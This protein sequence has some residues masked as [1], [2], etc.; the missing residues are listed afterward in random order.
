MLK[1]LRC[2]LTLRVLCSSSSEQSKEPG[3]PVFFPNALLAESVS[4]CLQTAPTEGASNSTELPQG[5]KDE[6][7]R[8]SDNQ[9]IYQDLLVSRPFYFCEV[10]I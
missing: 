8:P 7:Y 10:L 1:V 4:M 3:V 9:K 5:T 2:L 6:P